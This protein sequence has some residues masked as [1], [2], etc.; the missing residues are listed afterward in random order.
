MRLGRSGRGVLVLMAMLALLLGNAVGQTHR[1]A[2]N[3]GWKFRAVQAPEHKDAEEWRAATVPSV[4]QLDLRRAGLI[5]DPFFADNERSLQWIGTTD[6]EYHDEFTVDTA[7]L[8]RR[9]AELVFDGLDTFADIWLNG[10]L[11]AHVDNMFR[12]WRIDV[13]GTFANT[14][15]YESSFTRR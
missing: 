8:Q 3:A 1:Q 10:E 7:T 14:T 9:H 6:W 5:P 11:L 4:V 13:T 12:T 2:L 15:P